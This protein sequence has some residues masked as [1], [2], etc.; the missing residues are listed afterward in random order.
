MR[1]LR[2]LSAL[3]SAAMALACLW[4]CPPYAL[5]LPAASAAAALAGW[6]GLYSVLSS[7]SWIV[8][9]AYSGAAVQALTRSWIGLSATVVGLAALD[10]DARGYSLRRPGLVAA[11]LLVELSA[12][13]TVPL[14][15]M[16]LLRGVGL[17]VWLTP[18]V[19][20]AVVLAWLA[21]R[22][23]SSAW[24]QPPQR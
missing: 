20:G 2:V 5:A 7:L 11:L 22:T 19:T 16:L 17:R 9:A 10:A 4:W 23:L 13:F 3:C 24:R 18:L 15:A 6:I 8:L 1:R 21:V 14:A 12:P